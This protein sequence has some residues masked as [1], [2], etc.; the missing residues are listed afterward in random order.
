MAI[1][2]VLTR[3]ESARVAGMP[4]TL[5]VTEPPVAAGP[6]AFRAAAA[7]HAPAA[8]AAVQR[9]RRAAATGVSVDRG[10]T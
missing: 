10:T 7:Q 5:H 1:I 3:V 6:W 4:R 9:R 2:T 8:A